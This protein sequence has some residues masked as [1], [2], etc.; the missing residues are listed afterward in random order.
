MAT[1]TES[2]VARVAELADVH[3]TKESET[4]VPVLNRLSPAER[5][6][7]HERL[8]GSSNPDEHNHLPKEV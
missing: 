5:R 3:P 1:Q 4:Y 8:T 2:K 6:L 7:L